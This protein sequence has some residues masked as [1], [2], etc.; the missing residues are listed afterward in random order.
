M[1][2]S[3]KFA[4][5][6]EADVVGPVPIMRPKDYAGTQ[7]DNTAAFQKLIEVFYWEWLITGIG[8]GGRDY[9]VSRGYF[10]ISS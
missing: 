6:V 7:V 3:A 1:V 5:K 4:R 2:Y 10:S 8:A 9:V